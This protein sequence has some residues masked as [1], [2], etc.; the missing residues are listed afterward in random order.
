MQ[1]YFKTLPGPKVTSLKLGSAVGKFLSF[2]T[3]LSLYLNECSY[4]YTGTSPDKIFIA[5][6]NEVRGYTKKGKLFLSFDSNLTEPIIA[7]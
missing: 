2:F 5:S 6:G 3:L 1:L 4:W 7:M